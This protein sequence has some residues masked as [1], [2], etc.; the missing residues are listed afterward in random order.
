MFLIGAKAVFL[1]LFF[2]YLGGS[3]QAS[4]LT[5]AT[6]NAPPHIIKLTRSGID[7]D[8]TLAVLSKMGHRTSLEFM[9]LLRGKQQVISK[10][11]DLFL[12]TFFENDTELLFISDAIIDYR[13]TFFTRINDDIVLENIADLANKRIVTFQGASK[14]FGAEFLAMSQRNKY[15]RELHPMSLLPE[16]LLKGRY[17][18][19]LLDYYIFYYFLESH[20][21]AEVF[22]HVI[23]PSVEAH[24]GFNNK[25]LR[26]VFNE[27]LVVFKKTPAYQR[28]INNYLSL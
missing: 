24:V 27:H 3:L 4:E 8:I 14:Y 25:A 21:T 11:L 5:I 12:P 16:L 18:V 9:P 6:D 10:K 23:F 22:E 13:P 1:P 28:I 15:Y 19:V 26:D 20:R 17:D 2:L 7:L